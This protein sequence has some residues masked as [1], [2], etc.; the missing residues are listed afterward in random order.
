MRRAVATRRLHERVLWAVFILH[1]EGAPI[2][3]LNAFGNGAEF[4]YPIFPTRKEA[5]AWAA[6][7]HGVAVKIAPCRVSYRV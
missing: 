5:R 4:Q 2:W 1:E 6:G 7:Q 3:V